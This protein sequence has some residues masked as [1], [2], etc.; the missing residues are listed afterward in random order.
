MLPFL[1]HKQE[2]V[3][4]FASSFAPKSGIGITLRD[5]ASRLLRIP[6]IS[7]YLIGRELQDDIKLPDYEF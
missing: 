5:N 2:S 7:N 3:L 6:F 4:K 1:K